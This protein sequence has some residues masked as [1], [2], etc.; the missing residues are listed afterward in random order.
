MIIFVLKGQGIKN[1]EIKRN[2]ARDQNEYYSER[3]LLSGH[4]LFNPQ[5]VSFK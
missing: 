3:F 4:T 1:N 5:I 2:S